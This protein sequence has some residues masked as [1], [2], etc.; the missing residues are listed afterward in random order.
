[1]SF[2]QFTKQLAKE[3]VGNQLKDVMDSLRPADAAAK[4]DSLGSP[5]AVSAAPADNLAAIVIA[6][7]QA[8]QGILKEDQELVVLC[9]IGLETLR[10][11]E[12]YAP[13]PRVLVLTGI[14]SDG[15][16]SRVISPVESLQLVCKPMTVQPSAKPARIRFVVPKP[17]PE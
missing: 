9:T 11:L 7:V 4:A 14:D 13:S 8:M 2:G 16:I 6:Q 1:M 12:F 3:A 17:K 5:A 15:A 10:A